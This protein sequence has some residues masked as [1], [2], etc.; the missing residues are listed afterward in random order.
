MLSPRR[1]AQLGLASAAA[2]L[3]LSVTILVRGSTTVDQHDR[4]WD[5][6]LDFA[7][8]PGAVERFTRSGNRLRGSGAGMLVITTAAGCRIHVKM[9]FLVKLAASRCG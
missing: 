8:A 7:Q 4:A 5:L 9:P 6:R 2:V 3:A 1:S